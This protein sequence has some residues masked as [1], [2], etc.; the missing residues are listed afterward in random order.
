M[1]LTL[2]L[3]H[4]LLPGTR[5]IV[6]HQPH[7]QARPAFGFKQIILTMSRHTQLSWLGAQALPTRILPIVRLS[8][9]IS[10]LWMNALTRH[11][12]FTQPL[13]PLHTHTTSVKTQ[14]VLTLFMLILHQRWIIVV[15][16][17][18]GQPPKINLYSLELQLIMR[19]KITLTSLTKAFMKDVLG[20]TKFW[21]ILLVVALVQ[22]VLIALY[23]P[24]KRLRFLLLKIML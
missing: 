18:Y 23:L 16:Q 6:E 12:Q 19:I 22:V 20:L 2:L 17:L 7:P 14:T 11:F 5:D 13:Y 1:T 8:I 4:P 21:S 10:T 15:L 24:V 9:C 3:E